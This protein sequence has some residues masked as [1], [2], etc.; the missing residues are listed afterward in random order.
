MPIVLEIN[1]GSIFGFLVV[2]HIPNPSPN[3]SSN[4]SL[5]PLSQRE[6]PFHRLMSI[7]QFS[8]CRRREPA[9]LCGTY[10]VITIVTAIII[11]IISPI[12]VTIVSPH[13]RVY[14]IF[15]TYTQSHRDSRKMGTRRPIITIIITFNCRHFCPNYHR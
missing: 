7:Q 14:I 12:I 5:N 6:V 13:F 10:V 3:P 15:C 1:R 2:K 4:P 9:I 11:T 8:A